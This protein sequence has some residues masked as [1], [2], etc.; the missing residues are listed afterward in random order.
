M[1]KSPL[2]WMVEPLRRYADFRGRSGRAEFWWW[3]LA[4]YAITILLMLL[5]FSGYPWE[6]MFSDSID[7][8]TVDLDGGPFAFFGLSTWLGFAL[9]FIFALGTLVPS[10][11]VFVRRLHDRGMSGWW[12]AGV[13]I[14]NFIPI[15]NMLSF[16]GYIG[17]LVICALL[18]QEGPNR[19]GPDPK[20]PAQALVFT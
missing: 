9:Y 4:Y 8:A 16:F 6:L 5:V 1:D 3:T 19:W 12:L 10:L 17:L 15:L 7:P 11:A 2:Q 13:I 14:L 18:G 20:D